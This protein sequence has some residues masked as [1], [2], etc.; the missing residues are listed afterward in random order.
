MIDTREVKFLRSLLNGDVLVKNKWE[1]WADELEKR[2]IVKADE[3]G[4][5]KLVSREAAEKEVAVEVLGR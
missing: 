3:K 4:Y 1:P 2:G 5:W